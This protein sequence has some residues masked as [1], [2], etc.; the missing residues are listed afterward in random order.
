[1]SYSKKIVIIGGAGYLGTM[2]SEYLYS[3]GYHV[4]IIDAL[5]Y[6]L[7]TDQY[8]MLLQIQLRDLQKYHIG[9][10]DVVILLAGNSGVKMSSSLLNT[11]QQ[12]VSEFTHILTLLEPHQK[13]I[14]ASSVTVY[15]NAETKKARDGQS[16]ILT[17]EFVN[18]YDMT[19][20]HIDDII[21]F[22][23]AEYY[24]LRFG[25]INGFSYNFRT[26]TMINK[27]I[28][29]IKTS[30]TINIANENITRG[31]LSIND[32]IT[33]IAE[34]I[35]E[36]RN[37]KGIYNLCSFNTTVKQIKDELV[38]QYKCNVNMLPDT[39]KTTYDFYLD[40]TKFQKTFNWKP[41]QTL[42]LVIDDIEKSWK[43]I[44]NINDRSY[45]PGYTYPYAY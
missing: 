15:G 4:T 6:G 10:A 42:E 21:Q 36:K 35:K 37:N 34:I 41:T 43:M 30:N 18:A 39:P 7:H 17:Q 33:A 23:N 8:D 14:Y 24:G 13:F 5:Y 29:D 44:K 28:F 31:L 12:N 26:D 25:A 32:A 38:N 20:K 9:S 22:S 1:M 16:D 40:T 3:F 11:F 19:K 2:L 27:M 45:L